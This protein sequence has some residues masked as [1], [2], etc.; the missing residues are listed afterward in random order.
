MSL[1]LLVAAPNTFS[2][3]LDAS[4]NTVRGKVPIGNSSLVIPG[5][6]NSKGLPPTPTSAGPSPAMSNDPDGMGAMWKGIENK[7]ANISK[8]EKTLNKLSDFA[9]A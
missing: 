7:D 9:S 8:G 2:Q 4:L 1:P 5:A 6:S 3:D